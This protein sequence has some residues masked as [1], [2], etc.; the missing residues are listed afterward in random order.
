VPALGAVDGA[1]EGL[2]LA[3]GAAPGVPAPPVLDAA[4]TPAKQ[5]SS[6]KNAAMPI[7]LASPRGTNRLLLKPLALSLD[8]LRS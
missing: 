2:P 6:R 7:R 5:V 8:R 4:A 3:V 1:P